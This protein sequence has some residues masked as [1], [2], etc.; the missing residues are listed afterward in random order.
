MKF[1]RDRDS[2]SAP[3]PTASSHILRRLEDRI[4]FD[5]VMDA[6]IDPDQL[7][8]SADG[9]GFAQNNQSFAEDSAAATVDQSQSSNEGTESTR[10]LILIDTSVED[11]E[12]IVNEL[13]SEDSGSRSFEVVFLDRHSDGVSQITEI[14]S[15]RDELGA[16]H[17]VSHGEDGSLRLG[18]TW[19]HSGNLDAHAGDIASWGTSLTLDG[20]LLIYGCD[21]AETS[22]GQTF[23]DALSALTGADVAAS[24]DDTGDASRGGDWELEYE[25]GSIQTAVFASES[26][27]QAYQGL[28]A[29]GPSLTAGADQDVMIG[30]SFTFDVVFDNTG[31]TTGY[32]PFID[33]ILPTNG[34]DGV[35]GVGSDGITF[36]N[37]AY[38]GTELN[39]IQIVFPDDGA[40]TG[41]IDH[42]YAVDG[43]GDPLTVTGTAGD[44]LVV[45]ELPFGSVTDGQPEI[46]VQITATLSN[47]ADVAAP[48]AIQ[49]RSGFRYGESSSGGVASILDDTGN[50]VTDASVA[51][52]NWSEQISITPMLITVDK[53]FV[54]PEDETATGPNYERQYSVTVDIADGQT[55]SS[56]DVIDELPDNIVLTSIDTVTVG[57][58]AAAFTSN[59]ASMS[60]P[61]ANQDL[62]VTLDNDVT[63]TTDADDVVVTFSFYVAE[64]DAED[65]EVIPVTGEDDTTA[66][67][68]SRSLNN[69]SAAGDWNPID[70]RDTATPADPN[71]TVAVSADPAGFEH[72]LDN[73]AIAIQKSVA[74]VTETGT[75]GAT[76]GDTLEYTLTFQISDYFT[77]GD[78][79][80]TDIFQD[81]QE[82][83][84]GFG[85]TFDVTD[86]VGNV[87]GSFTVGTSGVTNASQRLVVDRSQIDNSDDAGEDGVMDDGTDGSTSLTFDVSGMMDDTGVTHDGVLQGGLSFNDND[88]D[89]RTAATGTIRFRTVIQEEY[90]DSFPSGDRSVD[91]GD[92]I[93]NSTLQISGTVRQNAEEDTGGGVGTGDITSVVGNEQDTSSASIQIASGTLTKEVYAINGNTTLPM[94]DNGLPVLVAGDEVTYRITYTLPT[95]DVEDLV[96]TDFLPLPI[97]VAGDYD[98]DGNLGDTWTVDFD[99]TTLDAV[100]GTIEL[101]A[102]DTFFANSNI[103]PTVTV[104]DSNGVQILYGDYDEPNSIGDTIELYLTVTA[105]NAPTADGLF[106]T[107][108]VRVEEGTTQQEPTV[109][110]RIIQIEVTQPVLN[111][112]K[113]ILDSDSLIE[114]YSDTIGPGGVT[115][116]AAGS[117]VVGAPFTGV[118]DSTK[119]AGQSIDAN[120]TGGIDAGDVVRYAIVVENTGSSVVGAF[121]VAIQDVLPE[122][123]DL[124]AG[125]LQVVDGTGATVNFTGTEADLFAGGIVLVDSSGQGSI[126]GYDETSGENVILVIY[127]VEATVAVGPNETLE[128]LAAVT[129]FAGQAGGETHLPDLGLDDE[130]NKIL[131]AELVDVASLVTRNVSASKTLVGTSINVGGNGN[132]DAVIGEIATYTVTFTIPEGTSDNVTIVDTLDSGLRF[133]QQTAANSNNVTIE[134]ATTPVISSNGRVIT[135]D[136]GD[137]VDTDINDNIDGTISFTYEVVVANLTGNQNTTT[138]DNNASYQVDGGQVVATTA[139]QDVTVVE[140][141]VQIDTTVSVAGVVNQTSGDAGDAISFVTTLTQTGTIDA[142]D[143]GFSDDLPLNSDGSSAILTPTFTVTDSAS[144]LTAADFEIIGDQAN[145]FTVQLRSGIDF[146]MLAADAGRT[147]TITVNG[148]IANA[149]T[150]NQTLG[151]DPQ[152]TWTSLDGDVG[153]QSTHS[154]ADTG[155]RDGTNS[156]DD[157]HDYVASDAINV[158]INQPAFTKSLFSTNETETNGSNVTIGERATFALLVNM[159]EGSSSGIIVTDQIPDGLDYLSFTIVTDA[160]SSGGLLTAD[161]NGSA[162]TPTVAGGAADGDDVSFTFG[163]ITTAVDNDGGNNS[164]VILVETVVSDIAGNVGTAAGVNQ[165]N[166]S[167]TATLDVLDDGTGTNLVTSNAVVIDVVEPDLNIVKNIVAADANAG[168]EMTITLTVTNTGLGDAYDVDIQDIIDSSHYDLTTVAI[169]GGGTATAAGFT[170]NYN[171]VSGAIDYTGGTI[172]AGATATF[173]FRATL[174][175]TVAT[176][177]VLVNTANLTEASTLSG[178][179]NGE[180]DYTDSANDSVHVREHSLSGFVYFDA[181]NDGVK[182]GS[183][184]G[185]QFVDVTVTGTDHLNNPVNTTVQTDANGNYFFGDLRPGTY[186]ITQTQPAAGTAPGSRDYLDGTDAIGTPGGNTANDVFSNIV[187]PLTS[188]VDGANNN[189]GELIEAE[190]SGFVYHDANNNGVKDLGEAGLVGIDVTLSGTDDNGVIANQTV[191]TGGDGSFSFDDLRP[192]EYSLTHVQVTGNAPSGRAYIDGRD[193]DGSLANG[194]V[195]VNEVT[196]SV[197]VVAG[198]IGTNYL[199]GEVVESTVSGYVFHDTEND[200]S[201]SGNTGLG[202]ITVTLT[203]TDDL[204]NN[205]SLPTTT[206]NVSGTLGFYEFTNLRPSDGTG[207]TITQTTPS[208]YIDGIDTIGSQSGTAA[209]DAFTSVILSDINGAENNFGEILPSSLAGMVFN[210]KDNDGVFNGTDTRIGGVDVTLTGFDDVGNTVN[211]TVK[212]L[213]DGT[214]SFTGLRPSGTVGYTITETQPTDY[215]DGIHSDGS[216]ANGDNSVSNVISSINLNEDTDGTAY[217]FAERGIGIT[218]TVF[219]DDN[220]D[221]DLDVGEDVRL[222]GI[223][224]EL[225]DSTDTTMLEFTTTGADGRYLF[226]D[227]PADDYIVKQTQPTL[228]TT[229]SPNT[230]N[231]TLPLTGVTGVDFGEALWDIGDMIYFDADGNGVQGGDEPGLG[232]IGVTLTYAGADGDFSTIGDNVTAGTITAADGSYEFTEQFNGNYR[233]TIDPATLPVGLTGTQEIDDIAAAIDGTSNITV[234]DDDRADIDFGFT[235]TGSIGDEVW[236]DIN[237]DGTRQAGETG[238]ADITVDLTFSGFDG[239]FGNADDF[240]LATQTDAN[241]VYTFNN[242]PAGDFRVAVDTGDADLPIDI[243]AIAGPDSIVGTASVTLTTGQTVDNIDFGFAGTLSI[244]DQVFI[245]HNADGGVFDAGDGDRGIAGVTVSLDIDFDGDGSFDHTLTTTT[246]TAGIYSFDSL[247][248][249]D[250]RVRVDNIQLGENVITTSTYE[251]DATGDNSS[252]VTLAVGSD[253][254]TA[255][256][257]Y[258]GQVEYAVTNVSSLTDAAQGRDIYT[259]EVTVTNLGERDGT[260]VVVVDTFPMDILDPSGMSTDDPA[261]SSWDFS[262]GELTWN[263]GDLDVG[264]SETIIVTVQVRQFPLDPLVNE[265]ITIAEVNDDTLNGPEITLVNNI[266]P[267]LDE[268]VVFTF[269]TFRNESPWDA[270][271]SDENDLL[272]GWQPPSYHE[273]ERQLRPAPVD[274]IFSGLAEPGTTLVLRIY[275]ESG[276]LIG[277]RQVVAD[278]GGNWLATFPGSVIWKQPHRM[279]IEQ[280]ASI[281]NATND[282]GFNLRRYF[283]PATHASLVMTERPTVSGTLRDTAYETIEVMHEAHTDPLQL[284]KTA[285]SYQLNTASTNVSSH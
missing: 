249:G 196:S 175:E 55:I 58:V 193:T 111:L 61:A 17:L 250:Y 268:L 20:D 217:N 189:F 43:S 187:L 121:D 184:T 47:L 172:A 167:N 174:L 44:T 4:L 76:P 27:Q 199:F 105:T 137:V 130:G 74:I 143:L 82:F 64:F 14:L 11:Y 115:F 253:D 162:P 195:T 86:S 128:T 141:S 26:L 258:P 81:G 25:S 216:L 24:D 45:V 18:N 92:T 59:I 235:G 255:D 3:S 71:A 108:I 213:A 282:A 114:T 239:V 31:D 70:D 65:D 251:I 145:G 208:G 198:D 134:N 52:T 269:D 97:F 142:F 67:P 159:P 179:V 267:T 131:P 147:V 285:H 51:A 89:V 272:L 161:Y 42:P 16:V 262:T 19:L 245:D 283:H 169:T 112:T 266:A 182:D 38:L 279:E 100:S 237:G 257:G 66:T 185:I 231:V 138:L 218:G 102:N 265:I 133:V 259:Y 139:D 183:E 171:N 226:A 117:A 186:T 113:G 151:I 177:A 219:V 156:A 106:L 190:L 29:A 152:V 154:T 153:N 168:D 241:G 101:G 209:N 260:G 126:A 194:N 215:N 148:T 125:S 46:G 122:G 164:F 39:V 275:D 233:V 229:T 247:V 75:T 170:G 281:E 228:Y 120:I 99:E 270:P 135:W 56:L 210:D 12:T 150:P 53:E 83:D 221:G 90:S 77:F 246:D 263:V 62:V 165:T 225:W 32:G 28:L 205:V 191:Q 222:S 214:Y 163:T 73:K 10:E 200:G 173:T 149:V 132:F 236:L 91:Q 49:T 227:R 96:M 118:V 95:S 261:N 144:N 158:T 23:V 109:I 238:L 264:Q 129:H 242:L 13:M 72:T 284:G 202:G 252:L 1:F 124:V 278:T 60:A 30:E 104:N 68:D 123:F 155:E 157:A 244:G 63:G 22:D 98:A 276:R 232:G 33:L 80:I 5:A 248:A 35:A 2:R 93:T 273:F 204:G 136:L 37:A 57:G 271:T 21:L 176:D 146:D 243:G 181:D 140:P 230:L 207:Y 201:R 107:N 211:I 119:L 234:L 127:D 166:L 78:L 206:S 54:G 224:I 85:A 280:V 48:L 256:F 50:D 188:E 8:A 197:N 180:R 254:L 240:V 110:D 36:G 79:V 6:G 116:D 274:P 203:G 69:V 220:R 192:G 223:R 103:T 160:A 7:D 212:T 40:G 94:G 87:T 84:F 41:T 178:D 34:T 88:G 9:A 15:S 277:D